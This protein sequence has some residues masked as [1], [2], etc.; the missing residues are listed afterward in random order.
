MAAN[1]LTINTQFN[2]Y[3][4]AEMLVPYQMYAE[5]Y[6]RREDL[7][8]QYS[9]VA[10]SLGAYLDAER[11]AQ[12]YGVYKAYSDAL[13]SAAEDLTTNGLSAANR[14]S[15][16]DLRRRFN[17]EITPIS[18]AIQA[19]Q[20]Y[21]ED[22][23]NKIDKDSTLLSSLNPSATSIDMFL[24][25]NT[26]ER[27]DVSGA[28]LYERMKEQASAASQRLNYDPRYIRAM[29]DQYWG[30]VQRKGFNSQDAQNF[31]SNMMSIPE[32]GTMVQSVMESSGA[33]NLPDI[34][35]QKALR[36]AIEGTLAG[37]VGDQDIDY[38]ENKAWGMV[39]DYGDYELP[40]MS[41]PSML[42]PTE[43][44]MHRLTRNKKYN[45][46]MDRR[47]AAKNLVEVSYNGKS[48]LATLD[49]VNMMNFLDDSQG[50]KY[51]NPITNEGTNEKRVETGK[52]REAEVSMYGTKIPG[53]D[54]V[55]VM[56]SSLSKEQV[57][58]RIEDY[59]EKEEPKYSQYLDYA[60]DPATAALI[61]TNLERDQ[62]EI[63][64]IIY[65]IAG[66][67]EAGN[68]D[69]TNIKKQLM[70][71]AIAAGLYDYDRKSGTIGKKNYAKKLGS[72][73]PDDMGIAIS[74]YGDIIFT[75]GGKDYTYRGNT[76][77]ARNK[78]LIRYITENLDNFSTESKERTIADQIVDVPGIR[79]KKDAPR[80]NMP[81]YNK[82]AIAR[83]LWNNHKDEMHSF[84]VDGID[85]YVTDFRDENG[86]PL[87]MIMTDGGNFMYM[88]SANDKASGNII[89]AQI[90]DELAYQQ[91][92]YLLGANL[93]TY[94]KNQ[95]DE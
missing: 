20:K 16:Q 80:Y 43:L 32:L 87:K 59:F 56:T 12:S 22:F 67:G 49:I 7:Q 54:K 73:D 39:P 45:E 44:G 55:P 60:D 95:E 69:I 40:E 4:L 52:Y 86:M 57:K 68:T 2:P 61:G 26:P 19:R 35:R 36:Y 33:I 25:G 18:T 58:K 1:Y 53:L 72:T 34:E 65:Q 71:Q 15:L 41:S 13:A 82:Y 85:Y 50:Y 76:D 28:L 70:S 47:E 78:T 84:N 81:F 23:N 21:I 17:R 42:S 14:R 3:T 46:Y 51:Y 92:G 91:L 8:N 93:D 24:N 89:G 27:L 74:R 63:S 62:Y 88:T 48:R 37:M 6:R 31:L 94:K 10:D 90:N 29:N 5:E 9:D 77:Y 11:D 66:Q 83:D 79:S 30:I 64:D 75:I 38:R